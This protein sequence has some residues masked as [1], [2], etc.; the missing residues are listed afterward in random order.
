MAPLWASTTLYPQLGN[1]Q[2]QWK[3]GFV[4]LYFLYREMQYFL[5]DGSVWD[6][7]V[8]SHFQGSNALLVPLL[9]QHE[10]SVL[11]CFSEQLGDAFISLGSDIIGCST[12]TC[13]A[14]CPWC[15]ETN[16]KQVQGC[17]QINCPCSAHPAHSGHI[18]NMCKTSPKS[19]YIIMATEVVV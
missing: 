13:R 15:S 5:V 9:C 17:W 1:R 18:C 14:S 2:P 12:E 6:E 11:L 10:S 7:L 3:C 8:W 16:G 4:Q 19:T